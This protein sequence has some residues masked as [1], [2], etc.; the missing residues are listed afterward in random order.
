MV[1]KQDPGYDDIRGGPIKRH[2]DLTF[3]LEPSV[4][5][6]K[7][8]KMEQIIS[9]QEPETSAATPGPWTDVSQGHEAPET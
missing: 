3:R 4:I 7:S 8:N 9:R 6:T 2:Q 5:C 1:K